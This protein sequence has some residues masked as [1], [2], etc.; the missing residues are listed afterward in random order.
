[1]G[2]NL[3]DKF[4]VVDLRIVN[5]ENVYCFVRSQTTVTASL[6]IATRISSHVLLFSLIA[7]KTSAV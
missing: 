2:V 4:Q 1:M 6:C 7:H 3:L 5:V